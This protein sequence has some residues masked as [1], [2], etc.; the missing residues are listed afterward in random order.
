MLF[1][2]IAQ[3][4]Y[5]YAIITGVILIFTEAERITIIERSDIKANLRALFEILSD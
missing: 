2:K 4:S 5:N 1:E 3:F